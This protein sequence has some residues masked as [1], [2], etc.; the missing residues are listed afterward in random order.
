MRIVEYGDIFINCT[1]CT[2]H[3]LFDIEGKDNGIFIM[4]HVLFSVKKEVK[5]NIFKTN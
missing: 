1:Y 3:T 4:E 2:S 5:I